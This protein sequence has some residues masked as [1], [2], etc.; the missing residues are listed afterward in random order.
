MQWLVITDSHTVWLNVK[1]VD[2]FW[3][4]FLRL[5]IGLVLRTLL[6]TV[7]ALLTHGVFIIDN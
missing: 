7:N 6:S 1:D 3:T 4:R 2:D 5:L